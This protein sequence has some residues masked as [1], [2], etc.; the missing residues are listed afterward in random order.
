MNTPVIAVAIGSLS[1]SSDF[2][3]FFL[4]IFVVIVAIR[5]VKMML[6]KNKDAPTFTK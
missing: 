3:D 2:G 6:S 5:I 4:R 1:S